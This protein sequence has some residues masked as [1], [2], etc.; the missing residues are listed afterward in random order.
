MGGPCDG[1]WGEVAEEVGLGARL[2]DEE[3]FS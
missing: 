2:E 3:L 1:T